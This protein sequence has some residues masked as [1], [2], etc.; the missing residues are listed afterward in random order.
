MYIDFTSTPF[1]VTMI[2]LL[3][4]FIGNRYGDSEK[5]TAALFFVG[6]LGFFVLII[7]WLIHLATYFF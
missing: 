1:I 6:I 5:P 7:Y 4:M 3:L 2:C